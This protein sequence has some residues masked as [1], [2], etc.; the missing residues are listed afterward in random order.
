MSVDSMIYGDVIE[1]FIERTVATIAK[2]TINQQTDTAK[3][4]FEYQA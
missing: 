3:V 1:I 2:G 4:S